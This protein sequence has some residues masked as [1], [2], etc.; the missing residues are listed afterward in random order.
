MSEGMG[1]VF[2]L[3]GEEMRAHPHALFGSVDAICEE[4]EKRRETYGI[5]Y[6]TVN[7]IQMEEFAPVVARLSGQ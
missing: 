1:N 2:G 3:S 6:V 7:D 4:L 5:T